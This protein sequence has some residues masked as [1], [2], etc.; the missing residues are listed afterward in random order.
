M[1]MAEGLQRYSKSPGLMHLCGKAMHMQ[2]CGSAL[3]QTATFHTN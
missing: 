2:A 1:D 3:A